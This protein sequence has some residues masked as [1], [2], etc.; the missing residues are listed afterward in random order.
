MVATNADDSPAPDVR[1]ALARVGLDEYVD[2]VITSADVGDHKPNYAF[3]RAA[4]LHEG[5]RGLPLDPRRAVMVGDN[6]RR[7]HRRRAASRHPHHL[8]QPDQTPLPRRGPAPRRG[9]PRSSP[10]CRRLVDKLAGVAPEKRALSSATP[11]AAAAATPAAVAAK[12]LRAAT[13]A[14]I[15]GVSRGRHPHGR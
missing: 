8:V 12:E 1:L 5:V 15:R 6:H 2:D 14:R 11:E 10:I 7:R 13:A 3:Y 9:D 4:L